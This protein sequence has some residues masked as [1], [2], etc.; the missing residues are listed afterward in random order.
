M[1]NSPVLGLT[2]TPRVLLRVAE[3]AGP[4]SPVQPTVPFPTTVVMMPEELII[5]MVAL[6]LFEM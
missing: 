1:Y 5:R 6:I 3:V 4:P 2:L